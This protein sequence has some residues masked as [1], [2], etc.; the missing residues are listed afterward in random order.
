M[1][2][3]NDWTVVELTTEQTYPLRRAVLRNDTPTDEVSFPEDAWPGAHHLGVIDDGVLIGTST[4]V[5][6][7]LAVQPEAIAVQLRGMATAPSY[8]RRGV[9]AALVAVGC[10]RAI[11]AGAQLVWANARDAALSFYT[12]HG[13]VVAGEGFIDATTMLPHHVVIRMLS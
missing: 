5:P 12:H 7:P 13:F 10:Q 2:A 6:R 11:D 9:G 1:T 8:Q 3:T 4:W